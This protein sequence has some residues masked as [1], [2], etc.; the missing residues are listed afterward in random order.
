MCVFHH[1][2]VLA[3]CW[4]GSLRTISGPQGRQNINTE[5][6][7]AAWIYYHA[8]Q[9]LQCSMVKCK[10]REGTQCDCKTCSSK[11]ARRRVGLQLCYLIQVKMF[12]NNQLNTSGGP[13]RNLDSPLVVLAA[14][15]NTHKYSYVHTHSM[16]SIPTSSSS[17][18]DALLCPISLLFG[19]NVGVQPGRVTSSTRL[20]LLS[21]SWK[22]FCLVCSLFTVFFSCC[23]HQYRFKYSICINTIVEHSLY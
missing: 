19:R 18:H 23:N 12:Y 15:K 6:E 3:E 4:L 16:S 17:G 11:C 1:W 9:A 2:L 7:S 10:W 8:V 22:I 5:L 20:I 13:Q 14:V 21:F